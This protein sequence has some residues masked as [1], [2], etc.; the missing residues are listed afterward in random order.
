MYVFE[1][2][3]NE[4]KLFCDLGAVFTREANILQPPGQLHVQHSSR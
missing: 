4:Y 3:D 1:I 2:S